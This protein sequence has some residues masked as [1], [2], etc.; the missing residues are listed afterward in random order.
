MKKSVLASLGLTL[1]LSCAALAD[2][3]VV[4]SGEHENFTRL[5]TPLTG[6]TDWSVAQ[7]QD[8]IIVT[9]E[10]HEDGFD[11]ARV[12]DLIPR[13]RVR[14]LETDTNSMT[15]SLACDCVAATFLAPGPYL[16]VDIAQKGV[17]LEGAP[18]ASVEVAPAEQAPQTPQVVPLPRPLP[19]K[20]PKQTTA[21]PAL[22][23]L[24]L[25][26][27]TATPTFNVEQP[28]LNREALQENER[29]VLIEMQEQLVRE[30]GSAATRGVLV[31]A[32]DRALPEIPQLTQTNPE[33]VEEPPEIVEPQFG[34]LENIRIS[35]SLD[36]PNTP[37]REKL[38]ISGLSC[39]AIG[40]L[41]LASWGTADPFAIQ[42]AA[43]RDGLFGE[44]DRLNH[45]AA[46]K[47]AQ[48]YL[49]FGFGAEARQILALEPKLMEEHTQL[50][51]IADIFDGIQPRDAAGLAR[52]LDCEPEVIL[53]ATLVQPEP[54]QGAKPDS[55]A[56]LRALDNLPFHLREILAPALSKK[57]LAYGDSNSAAQAL[58]SLERT[59]MR[60]ASAAK[61]A[62]AELKL[63]TGDIENGKAQL[64][65]VATNNSIDS[66]TAL[67]ALIDAK[68]AAKQPVPMKHAE[69]IE[70]YA[71]ELRETELGPD[72]RRTHVLALLKSGQFDE[73][74][75][76][77]AALGGDENTPVAK[78]LRA[79]LLGDLARYAD[80]IVFLEHIFT[81]SETDIAGL[82][83]SDLSILAERFL[84]TGFAQR[85]ERTIGFIADDS[86]T[87]DQK[88]LA[89]RIA[90]ALEKPAVAQSRLQGLETDAANTLRADAKRMAG[91]Y[92]EAHALYA[93]T[94][95]P[96]PAAEAA[97]MSQDWQGLTTTETPVF[98]PA[99]QLTGFAED[100][101]GDPTGMLARS[102][103]ALEES[104]TAR[105]TL[106]ELL[107]AA[108]LQIEN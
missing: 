79:H 70:A 5:V 28:A 26:R 99:T 17:S 31:P 94:D 50:L 18:V 14:L 60:L 92:E 86:M 55:D 41:D 90:L 40:A 64:E 45:T 1:G 3:A 10:N 57:L 98:G 9:F 46:V 39:P 52:A 77:N 81:Q 32:P 25:T 88:L 22:P 49:Y 76:A 33:I 66:P 87:A 12:F 106:L 84:T 105:Q 43:A 44:L 56:A 91:A 19:L 42:I 21:A 37:Q 15:V 97:W 65:E 48:L 89:A 108:E 101:T 11:T 36:R 29:Q 54:V 68:I 67:I 80:D 96:M 103:A 63:Q 38:E 4:Q 13:E 7:A 83:A 62:Q 59:P 35:S 24:L 58:R 102:S 2:P 27:R 95:Q 53:W 78:N 20:V 93:Q 6:V 107:G 71:Q 74:F 61:L 51:V 34:P 72:L 75:A 23:P 85:A 8:Q 104:E 100:V 82:H 73:A 16:V 30:L 47:L 69:L